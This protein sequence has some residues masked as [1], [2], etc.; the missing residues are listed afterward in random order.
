MCCLEPFQELRVQI[1]V[2]GK[3]DSSLV[4]DGWRAGSTWAGFLFYS[5]TVFPPSITEISDR[6]KPVDGR[7]FTSASPTKFVRAVRVLLASGWN[8]SD[9]AE[10]WCKQ[11]CGFP[12]GEKEKKANGAVV[13]PE[14]LEERS[15]P[16]VCPGKKSVSAAACVALILSQTHQWRNEFSLL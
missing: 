2:A 9:S 5:I 14:R 15:D 10:E 13:G 11:R 16:G 4:G 6:T 7:R 12:K 1:T 8:G 3:C